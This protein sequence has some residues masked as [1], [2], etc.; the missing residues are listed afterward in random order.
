MLDLRII[1]EQTD[2]VKTEIAKLNTDAPIDQIVTLDERRRAIT[3]DVEVL[4]ARL[5]A[6]SRETGR[7]AAGEER[8]QHIR[9]MR[10]LGEQ[11]AGLDSELSTVEAELNTQML[12]V[13]NLPASDV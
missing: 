8:N 12:L 10:A 13:P 4:R 7:I 6:G 11:I 9:D 5:N 3:T 1:R 2:L